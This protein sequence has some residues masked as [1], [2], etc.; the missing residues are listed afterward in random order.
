MKISADRATLI[1]LCLLFSLVAA[2]E[3]PREQAVRLYDEGQY[4]EART[5][6]EQMDGEGKTDGPLLYRLSFC[7]RMAGDPMARQTQARALA[8]LEEAVGSA[9]TL[10]VPFYLSNAYGNNAKLSERERVAREATQRVESGDLPAPENGLDWFRLA[11]LY[12]DMGDKKKAADGFRRA[13]AEFGSAG[14]KS[15]AAYVRWSSRFLAKDAEQRGDWSA[16]AEAQA[17]VMADGEGTRGDYDQLAVL[18]ARA[19]QYDKAADAWKKME[20]LDPVNGD[21]ARYSNKVATMAHSLGEL[22]DK[23]PDGRAW[24]ELTKEEL[25]ELM[26]QRSTNA[27]EA[28]AE[29]KQ[30]EGISND[31]REELREVIRRD[32]PVF[33]AAALE[34]I[35]RNLSIRETAFFGGYAPMIFRPEAWKI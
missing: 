7:Q 4:E 18:H 25:E 5:L 8:E 17:A 11:K 27:K 22:P 12:D 3:S 6:L 35:V 9:K 23:A 14:V 15:H 26:L 29:S 2:A 32:Q 21:R 1:C 19:K 16:A 20:R 31:R 34:Y 33:F 30:P 28:V 24:K 10:E 13:L